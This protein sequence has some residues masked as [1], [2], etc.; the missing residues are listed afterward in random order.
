MFIGVCICINNMNVAAS[1]VHPT[2]DRRTDRRHARLSAS[3]PP[4]A[5]PS[6]P[7]GLFTLFTA[8]DAATHPLLYAV[9][10]QPRP[11]RLRA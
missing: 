6:L 10:R 11:V 5:R 7:G 1:Y 4:V 3:L 9:R 2:P 8:G